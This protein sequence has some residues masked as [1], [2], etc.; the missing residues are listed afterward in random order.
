MRCRRRR[1]RSHAK[2]LREGVPK[3]CSDE[4]T[5]EL[6]HRGGHVKVEFFGRALQA[7]RELRQDRLDFTLCVLAHMEPA[8]GGVCEIVCRECENF[9]RAATIF[10]LARRN[11]THLRSADMDPLSR[12]F[13]FSLVI[14][15]RKNRWCSIQLPSDTPKSFIIIMFF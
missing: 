1:R 4:I 13:S 9:E 10:F 12:C 8:A 3:V 15:K 5:A 14:S 7:L 6:P 11:E 2:K